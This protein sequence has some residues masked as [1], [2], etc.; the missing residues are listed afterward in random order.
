MMMMMMMTD[1]YKRLCKVAYRLGSDL[2]HTILGHHR[3]KVQGPYKECANENQL[4]V[5]SA[6]SCVC[7]VS[8]MDDGK[9][10]LWVICNCLCGV[11]VN[12]MEE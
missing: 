10:S 6:I 11:K 12:V 2:P 1:Y 5:I 4:C 3:R 9:C 7:V 8:A